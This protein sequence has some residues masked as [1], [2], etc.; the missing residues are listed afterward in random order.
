MAGN[1]QGWLSS[2]L[3]PH[4]ENSRDSSAASLRIIFDKEGHAYLIEFT[5]NLVSFEC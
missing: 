3:F 5:P 1:G 4:V 2:G